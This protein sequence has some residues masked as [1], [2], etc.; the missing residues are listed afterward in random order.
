M[1][2]STTLPSAAS[3]LPCI[4]MA[5]ME[6]GDLGSTN[7]TFLNGQPSERQ[8]TSSDVVDIGK[9]KSALSTKGS[10]LRSERPSIFKPGQLCSPH[11]RRDCQRQCTDPVS[12]YQRLVRCCGRSRG[13]AGQDRDDH[14]QTWRGRSLDHPPPHN[15]V[16]THVRRRP[17]YCAH[18]ATDWHRACGIAR[19]RRAGSGWHANC[20]SCSADPN[21]GVHHIMQVRVLG[22][23]GAIASTMPHHLFLLNQ[24]ILIDAGNRRGR[25]ARRGDA[26]RIDHVLLSHSHLD[27]IAALP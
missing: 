12:E 25:P 16:L 4:C 24:H 14:W 3:M 9:Y 6:N 27:H 20:N 11:C 7:G 10:N 18:W 22:C 17:R 5:R 21:T 15:Y 26:L 2:S 13:R 1:W 23:S 8:R 19:W